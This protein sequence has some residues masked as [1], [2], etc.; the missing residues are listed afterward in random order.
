MFLQVKKII[1]KSFYV[2]VVLSIFSGVISCE[3]DFTDIG[4]GIITNT[5]FNTKDTVLDILITN[6]PVESFKSDNISSE[7]GQ[8]L[9]GVYN[10]SDYE[11]IEASIISQI[12]INPDLTLV[13]N[14]YGADTTVV[15]TIDTVFVKLPYQATLDANTSSGPEYTLDSITGDQSKLFSLNVYQLDT[16]LSTLNPS[17]PSK[18]NSYLSNHPFQ[19]TGT[20]LNSEVDYQFSPNKND[21]LLIVKRRLS[22][23]N[24]YDQDT[25]K[26]SIATVNFAPLPFVRIPLDEDKFKQLFLDK[27]ESSEFDSQDAFNDYFRGVILEAKGNDGSLISFD[28]INNNPELNPSIEVYYTNTVLK[29][30]TIVVDTIKKRNT[31][32]LSGIRS[33]SFKMQNRVYPVNEEVKI[34]GTAGSE[35]KIDILIGNQ[36]SELRAKN[37]LINDASLTFYINQSVDT[38]SVPHRLYLYKNGTSSSL[39]PIL[40]QVKDVY[41]ELESTF[42]GNLARENSK[43]NSYTFRITDYIS[44]ILSGETN[45]SPS[46][47]LKAFNTSD[48]PV[49]DSLFIQQSWNPK[50]VTILNH[51]SLNGA[52]KAQ[53]KISYSEKK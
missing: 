30:G 13:D 53:L 31:F 23:S 28:F 43:V 51:S 8:Y 38:A 20:E 12:V 48:L 46:L 17:D 4:T 44:D 41:S 19:K 22:N 10:S 21:T 32:S 27:Y 45:Y 52:R 25:I 39:Q 40:S 15:S 2:G 9:L 50:A 3:K 18:L 24:I 1:K 42:G 16:Y 36:I 35:A 33:N 29:S 14:T 11:K 34:Q 7:Q 49:S 6:S 47:K 26:Y 5:Q 37:W